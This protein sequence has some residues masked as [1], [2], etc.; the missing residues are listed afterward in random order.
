MSENLHDQ[1]ARLLSG[2]WYTQTIYVAAKLDL[3]ELLKDSRRTVLELAEATGTDPRAL[4]R[5]L[6]ALAS[7]GIF[8]EDQGHFSLTP[9]AECLLDP[10]T[11]A[12]ATMRGEFQYRAWGELLYSVQ[13]G[14]S[15]FEKVYGMP[16][17]DFFSEHPDAGN[18]FDQAMTGVHG[19]E[20]EAML[21]AYDFTR[22]KTLADIGGG[23][24]SVIT[25]ILRRYPTIEGI[26]FDLPS[27]VERTKANIEAAGL[28][29]RCQV[30]AGNVFESV[31]PGADAYLMRHIIHDWDDDKSLTILRNCRRAMG[32]GGK[33]LVVE[34]V[35]PPGNEPSVSKFFDL[36][37]MVLP[38]GME[39]TEEEY[40]LLFETAG[41]RLTRIVPTRTW[42]SLIEGEARG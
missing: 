31:P 8:A 5:L 28:A 6:R 12:M 34:G 33:L 26:L 20:T 7:I 41:F 32:K 27:V 40:R 4:Y 35:V 18:L 1:L 38:G 11:K 14:K 16:I 39:R 3:A 13:S 22:I 29:E 21:D 30:M 23:N 25:A 19:R 2:Y 10:S 36:A 24:G 37:M 9:L 17:F 15:A 42:V